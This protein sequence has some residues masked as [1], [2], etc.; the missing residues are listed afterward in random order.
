M[1]DEWYKNIFGKECFTCK[2]RKWS[3][4]R[5]SILINGKSKPKCIK[6]IAEGI[7]EKPIKAKTF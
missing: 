6:C 2:R 4:R 1:T 3:A 5:C 7:S